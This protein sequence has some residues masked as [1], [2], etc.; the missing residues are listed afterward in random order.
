MCKAVTL[1][2]LKEFGIPAYKQSL[3][4]V[5]DLVHRF[6]MLCNRAARFIPK[7]G[8]RNGLLGSF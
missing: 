1:L 6:L 2:G 3:A 7:Y 8:T 5:F 4:F